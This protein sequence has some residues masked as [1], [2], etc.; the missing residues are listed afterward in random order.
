MYVVCLGNLHAPVE[1]Q[2]TIL[3]ADPD[4]A[5]DLSSQYICD[6][7]TCNLAGLSALYYV[8]LCSVAL[9]CLMPALNLYFWIYLGVNL[10][11]PF[12]VSDSLL[13]GL[14]LVCPLQ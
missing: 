8:C 3:P 4:V 12:L 9:F 11:Q 10:L 5:D 14:Y 2:L 6:S 1:P 13:L 7:V